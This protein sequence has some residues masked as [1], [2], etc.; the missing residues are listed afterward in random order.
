MFAYILLPSQVT[1]ISNRVKKLEDVSLN[2]SVPRNP[3]HVQMSEL[4][5]SHIMSQSS[6]STQT[7]YPVLTQ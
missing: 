1:F 2:R 3:V 5:C 7:G 6:T 4:C